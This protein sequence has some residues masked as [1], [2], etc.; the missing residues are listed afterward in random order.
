MT[1]EDKS[2][3]RMTASVLNQAPTRK[4]SKQCLFTRTQTQSV[5]IENKY[6]T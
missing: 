3:T 2:D 6:K 4:S 1:I 5:T